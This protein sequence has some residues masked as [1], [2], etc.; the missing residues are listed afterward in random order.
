MQSARE[1]V[2]AD[3]TQ[4]KICATPESLVP[5]R[6]D[7]GETAAMRGRQL[8]QVLMPAKHDDHLHLLVAPQQADATMFVKSHHVAARVIVMLMI[9]MMI[10]MMMMM[11][12]MMKRSF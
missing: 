4:E 9:I 6:E 5:H 3:A 1:S 11:M 7:R 10:M 2:K 12:M 8:R